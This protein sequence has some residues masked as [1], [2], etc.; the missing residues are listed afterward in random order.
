MEV[1]RGKQPRTGTRIRIFLIHMPCRLE[2]GSTNA[3]LLADLK[4]RGMMEHTLVVWA[5]EFGCPSY[6]PTGQTDHNPA[7]LLPDRAGQTWL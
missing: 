3:A 7:V 5:T 2:H 4:Q 6:N 1:I